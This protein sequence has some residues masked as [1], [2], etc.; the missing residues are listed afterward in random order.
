VTLGIQ[1]ATEVEI[2]AGLHENDVVVFGNQSQYKTGQLVS[3]KI[4]EPGQAEQE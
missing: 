1:T 4:V 2:V 3:P